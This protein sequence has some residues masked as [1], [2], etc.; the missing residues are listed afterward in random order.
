MHIRRANL[1]DAEGIAAI[2]NYEANQRLTVF[3]L[4]GRTLEEQR[5]WLLERSG[6]HSVIVAEE[7]ESVV[8]FAS[9]SPFRTRPAY[10]TTVECSVFVRRDHLRLGIGKALLKMLIRLASEHGFH[11]MIARIADGNQASIGLHQACGFFLVGVERE[12]GRKF[13]RWLDVTVMQKLLQSDDPVS[14]DP[15]SGGDGSVS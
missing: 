5:Q 1:D 14:D 10:N 3:D 2:Y 11:C 7:D 4:R 12:V 8:G 13:N 6:A 9:L 15:V